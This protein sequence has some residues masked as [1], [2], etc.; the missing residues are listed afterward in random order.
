MTGQ[1][2]VPAPVL[3]AVVHGEL[4]TLAP[5]TEANGVVARGAARLV[6]AATGLDPHLLGVPEVTWLRRLGDYRETAARFGTGD[7]AA[8]AD[9]IVLCCEAM[10]AGAAEARSIADAARS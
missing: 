1:T 10:E 7:P 4:L 3:A 5:F 8:I 2:T 6:T 9:W